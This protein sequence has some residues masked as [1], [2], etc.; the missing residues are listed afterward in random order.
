MTIPSEMSTATLTIDIVDDTIPELDEIFSILLT[1]VELTDSVEDT[2]VPPTLGAN[3]MV[4]ITILA[5]DNPFGSISLA[6]ER[7]SVAEGNT[8]A[9]SLVRVGGT[10]GVS[11]VTYATVNGRAQSPQDYTDSSGTVVFAQGQVIAD[12]HV[13]TI[14]DVEPEVVEDFGFV[15]L[16]V[17]VGSLGNITMA[18][19]LI[20][21]SDSPFGA[22][23]FSLTD[24]NSGV[25]IANP[26]QSPA[27]VSLLIT[28]VG[29]TIGSTD[30][31]WNVT[32]PGSSGLP[33]A[34]IS[35]SSI[36]GVL[37]MTDGQRYSECNDIRTYL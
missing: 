19:I 8:I 24:V 26:T 30:I 4:Q 25:S 21:A 29:G 28:R 1:S 22:V 2:T 3:T 6:Q 14:D 20:E 10:L 15:L 34:D 5:S 13:S 18:T 37:T 33:S 36:R 11:T 27:S 7:Y 32:G 31:T 35:P 9:I 17:N 23:G 12:V 16:E